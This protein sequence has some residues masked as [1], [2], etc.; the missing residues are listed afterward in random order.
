QALVDLGRASDGLRRI[1][2]ALGAA[3]K[4]V[5]AE[6]ERGVALFELCRFGEARHMFE[7]VLAA[8]PDHGHALYHLGLID[9]REGN[10]SAAADRLAQATAHDP[11][12]FPPPPVVSPAEFQDH[13]RRALAALPG[14]VAADLKGID[15]Q[16]AELPALD[17]LTAEKPPLSPTILR[18]EEHT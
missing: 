18:S 16:A 4:L 7:K 14:D 15:V 12:A 8:T 10:D 2:A 6:Y 9:E 11:K 13:V 17:D 1:D 5:A 3:P